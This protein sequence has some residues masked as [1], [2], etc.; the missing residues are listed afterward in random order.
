MIR[1]EEHVKVHVSYCKSNLYVEYLPQ[2]SRTIF[3]ICNE[4]GRIIKTGSINDFETKI[5]ISELENSK[6]VLLILDGDRVN[7]QNFTVSR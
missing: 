2:T 7:S 3:D 6:Y 5:D 4:N 1:I